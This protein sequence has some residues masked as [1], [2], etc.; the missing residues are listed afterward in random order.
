MAASGDA[1]NERMIGA[2]RLVDGISDLAEA[3]HSPAVLCAPTNESP[4]SWIDNTTISTSWKDYHGP[5]ATAQHSC[6]LD[7]G[8]SLVDVTAVATSHAML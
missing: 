8:G 1:H 3:G 5:A 2:L 4:C 6:L 7:P